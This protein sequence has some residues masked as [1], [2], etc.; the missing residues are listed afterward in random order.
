MTRMFRYTEPKALNRF[1]WSLKLKKKVSLFL[2]RLAIFSLEGP[3]L[4]M[5]FMVRVFTYPYERLV[6]L[7]IYLNFLL[8][9]L[10]YRSNE[11]KNHL[12]NGKV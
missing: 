12:E 5:T 6:Q 4:L 11:T 7:Y 2:I 3:C 9:D 8:D 1:I 10:I